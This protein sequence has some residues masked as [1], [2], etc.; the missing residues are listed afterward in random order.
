MVEKR[1]FSETK[2][3][4]SV[5]QLASEWTEHNHTKLLKYLETGGYKPSSKEVKA[6]VHPERFLIPTSSGIEEIEMELDE[7]DI[8][9][10]EIA[11]SVMSGKKSQLSPKHEMQEILDAAEKQADPRYGAW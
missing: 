6:P 1:K 9:E 11:A 3:K 2:W 10:V 4:S 8:E 5:G 7:S